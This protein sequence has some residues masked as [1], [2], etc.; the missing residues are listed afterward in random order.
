MKS[1][2]N[3][4][5]GVREKFKTRSDQAVLSRGKFPS[6]PCHT[7]KCLFNFGLK[8]LAVN[9][10]KESVALRQSCHFVNLGQMTEQ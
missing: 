7:G 10:M 4:G 6:H 2:K 8:Q 1:G 9:S 5:F 3:T